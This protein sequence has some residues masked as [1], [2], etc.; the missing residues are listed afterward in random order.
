[1][2][3]TAAEQ[4]RTAE[5][6]ALSHPIEK[7][8]STALGIIIHR[9]LRKFRHSHI[10]PVHPNRFSDNFVTQIDRRGLL[11]RDRLA[12]A[13]TRHAEFDAATREVNRLYARW[14]EL[15]EK[16]Q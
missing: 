1:M 13:P 15:E 7:Q 12:I 9:G 16:R 8:P 2:P 10:L 4:Q 11:G 14:A 6:V 3:G 5:R